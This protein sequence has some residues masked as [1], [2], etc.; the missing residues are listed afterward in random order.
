VWHKS[1]LSGS[2]AIV[3]R[4]ADNLRMEGRGFDVSSLDNHG[5]TA[6]HLISSKTPAAVTKALV[7]SGVDIDAL[8]KVS[9]FFIDTFTTYSK[10]SKKS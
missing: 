7:A 8:N 9:L 5:N 10:I 4:L 3:E 2:A 6:L 1:G